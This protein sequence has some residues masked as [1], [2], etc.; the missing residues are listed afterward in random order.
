[1]QSLTFERTNGNIPRKLAG[2]DHISG[3]MFYTD[4]L[5]SG[6]SETERIKAVSQIETAEKLRIT[7]D[8][9]E[10][11]IRLMHYQLSEIFRLNPGISL[12]VGIFPKAEGANTVPMEPRISEPKNWRSRRNRPLSMII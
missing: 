12:Y 11:I 1:M 7:A 9:E 5:P 3:I 10:W 6:F 2:E 4:T 8:A